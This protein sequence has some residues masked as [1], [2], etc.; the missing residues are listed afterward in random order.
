MYNFLYR[1][2]IE[3]PQ[4]Q[5]APAQVYSNYNSHITDTYLIGT[6]PAGTLDFCLMGEWM[7][8]R[9]NNIKLMFFEMISNDD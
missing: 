6:T 8:L 2:I 4:N 5:M 1:N 3:Q 9:Q 7:H